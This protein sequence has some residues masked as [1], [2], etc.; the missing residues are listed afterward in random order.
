VVVDW[1]RAVRAAGVGNLAMLQGR[2]IDQAKKIATKLELLRNKEL[3]AAFALFM[4]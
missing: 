1:A 2:K 4:V 3:H